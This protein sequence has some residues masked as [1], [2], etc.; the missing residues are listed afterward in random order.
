VLTLTGLAKAHGGRTLFRDVTLLLDK[1][2]RIALLG[3]NGVGKT[4][5]LEIVMG[6]QEAD[7][8]AVHRSPDLEIG[9]LPQ[10]LTETATG[11]VLEEAMAGAGRVARLGER[12]HEIEAL[13]QEGGDA[14]AAAMDEY[15]EVQSAF[16]AQ[17]G[18]ALEAEAQRVLAGLGFATEDSGRPVRDLS[19]GWRMRVALA[20]LLLADPD[21]LLLDEPTNHL[22]VD[23]V[24]WLEQHLHDFSGALL[25]VSHDRD[26]IDGV[27]NHIVEMAG[28]TA[29]EYVG[30][31]ADFIIEREEHLARLEAAAARQDK[32]IAKTERFIERFR[33]KATKARQVQSRVKALEKIER[34]QV[35]KEDEIRARFQFPT[36]PRSPRVMAQFD[37]AEAGYDDEPAILS[38]VSL[39]VERGMRIGLVGP[40]GAGKTT[41]LKLLLGELAP[42]AGTVQVSP[43]VEPAAFAQHQAEVLDGDKR[44]VE[45]FTASVPE[46]ANKNRRTLLGSFGFSGD[47]ADRRISELSGGERTR[48]ALA[49][50]MVEPHNLLVLDEPTNHLDLPSCDIL[51]DALRAYDGTVLLVTHDRHLIR[52]VATSLIEVR[53]GH[54]IWYDGVDEDV[55]TP[56]KAAGATPTRSA[57]PAPAPPGPGRRDQRRTAAERRQDRSRAT[58][59]AKAAAREAERRVEKADRKVERLAAQ[60]ADPDLYD[61]PEK[62]ATLAREHDAAVAAMTAAIAEWERLV[63]ELERVESQHA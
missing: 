11:T 27:A 6:L 12:L 45:E 47:A 63:E 62:I 2:R 53:D 32:Q 21:V 35:P 10:D 43:A 4:T 49:K 5:L 15:G 34:V 52:S 38:D 31:F 17:G 40:N 61:Q 50:I 41:L 54:A 42:R 18:Y 59:P 24:G 39:F 25:F 28:G 60:L 22:D 20:R 16:E 14:A 26:F 55:L 30:A 8:G 7:T 58:K 36:P 44:V 33:Y 29:T 19:G 3:G 23:S 56:T 37:R 9:Y 13:L 46:S 1:G 51:E 48:L 57:A